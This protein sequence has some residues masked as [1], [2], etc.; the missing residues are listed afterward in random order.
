MARTV[1]AT[2]SGGTS[3]VIATLSG[4]A[5]TPSRPPKRSTSC[6]SGVPEIGAD[7]ETVAAASRESPGAAGS[8]KPPAGAR[9]HSATAAP[10]CAGSGRISY[11]TPPGS[12]AV[13][14]ATAWA[15][16]APATPQT[17]RAAETAAL[18]LVENPL[19]RVAERWSAAGA[20]GAP[21]A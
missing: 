11:I 7:A 16:A 5:A 12:V 19:T 14:G 20:L 6:A 15:P 10:D 13:A 1:W 2:R 9:N 21:G 3:A 4:Y 17:R 8:A 18:R